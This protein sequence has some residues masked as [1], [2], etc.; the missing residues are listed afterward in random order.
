MAGDYTFG[1]DGFLIG[2]NEASPGV[3]VY[4]VE[5]EFLDGKTILYTGDVT[6]IR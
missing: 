4:F 1:W 3:Y 2:N 5:Y 6:L